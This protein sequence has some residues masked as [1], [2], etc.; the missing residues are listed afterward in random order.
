MFYLLFTLVSQYKSLCE[1]ISGFPPCSQTIYHCSLQYWDPGL[2]P[3]RVQNRIHAESSGRNQS[4]HQNFSNIHL[5][6]KIQTTIEMLL[7]RI[8]YKYEYGKICKL[9]QVQI[10]KTRR[11]GRYAP[12]LLDPAEGWGPFGSIGAL[13]ALLG[14]F[15]PQ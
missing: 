8:L 3:P 9:F 7:P 12:I 5:V 4:S 2:C 13:R 15:G 10:Y 14:S 1:D 6:L 11:S